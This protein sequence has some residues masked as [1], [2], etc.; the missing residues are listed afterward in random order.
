MPYVNPFELAN[1]TPAPTL[2]RETLRKA[3]SVVMNQYEL[4]GTTN[5][6][7]GKHELNKETALKLMDQLANPHIAAFHFRIA[8]DPDLNQFLQGTM[9]AQLPKMIPQGLDSFS[10]FVLPYWISACEE[11]LINGLKDDQDETVEKV[12][13]ITQ[14]MIGQPRE[15][16]LKTSLK[17]LFTR[18]AQMEELSYHSPSE[19]E[20][21][22][23][24]GLLHLTKSLRHFLLKLPSV[25]G[26]LR[27]DYANMAVG[28]ALAEKNAN[29]STW[30]NLRAYV[31]D[32]CRQLSLSDDERENLY[33]WVEHSYHLH[34]TIENPNPIFG[35]RSVFPKGEGKSNP[36][37]AF[38]PFLWFFAVVVVLI[39]IGVNLPN[40]ED[41]KP[42]LPYIYQ[43]PS[44]PGPQQYLDTVEVDSSPPSVL[45]PTNLDSFIRAN[46]LF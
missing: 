25:H 30:S 15:A 36:K 41:K 44:P 9:P 14:Q 40:K 5:I 42:Y 35:S 4:E 18:M 1:I 38:P 6:R 45:S 10:K 24:R 22:K 33:E 37:V 27:F 43:D 31:A 16:V 29:H 23:M 21:E 12:M 46:R 39:I 20:M 19:Y 32:I 11:F 2:D 13:G 8:Q 26:Y 34:E 3:R 17:W 28:L 7:F